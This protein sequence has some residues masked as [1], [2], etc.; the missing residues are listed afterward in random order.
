MD[1][2]DL[3][4]STKNVNWTWLTPSVAGSFEEAR[5]KNLFWAED[6]EWAVCDA[7]HRDIL[8]DRPLACRARAYQNIKGFSPDIHKMF[9]TYKTTF[10]E[11]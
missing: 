8:D 7:C 1:H 2:C 11:A 6:E 5:E 3:C 9:W 4:N 10:S